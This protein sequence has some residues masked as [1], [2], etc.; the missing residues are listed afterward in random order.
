MDITD[1]ERDLIA[2]LRQKRAAQKAYDEA[3]TALSEAEDQVDVAGIVRDETR[4]AFADAVKEIG[5]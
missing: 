2:K 3:M 5:G 4:A 1:A